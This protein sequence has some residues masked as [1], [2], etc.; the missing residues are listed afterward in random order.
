MGKMQRCVPTI[1][2][3]LRLFRSEYGLSVLRSILIQ[4]TRAVF[5][6]ISSGHSHPFHCSHKSTS[7]LPSLLHE[8][9][10]ILGADHGQ[11]RNGP[12]RRSKPTDLHAPNIWD[13]RS[14]GSCYCRVLH[15]GWKDGR[16]SSLVLYLQL[17][18]DV[19]YSAQG[20][21]FL[22]NCC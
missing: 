20:P 18:G 13:G 9:T 5:V 12:L 16:D 21:S 4:H 10:T 11:H 15:R 14:H 19:S 3:Y 8:R 2:P 6:C 7:H 17:A 22:L 1:C